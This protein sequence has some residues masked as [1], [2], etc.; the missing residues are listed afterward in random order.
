M[1]KYLEK[2]NFTSF[3]L[4]KTQQDFQPYVILPAES[5]G[6]WVGRTSR[7]C[8]VQL[9][10]W[11]MNKATCSMP[12]RYL[13][14]KWSLPNPVLTLPMIWKLTICPISKIA[15]A[16]PSKW[17]NCPSE[18]IQDQPLFLFKHAIPRVEVNLHVPPSASISLNQVDQFS[19][20][21]VL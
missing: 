13:P 18:N 7:D 2:A 4:L 5:Q 21:P 6:C 14:R 15:L 20:D 3:S 8:L 19:W 9:P 16:F 1:V 12:D 17:S 11:G 10:Y